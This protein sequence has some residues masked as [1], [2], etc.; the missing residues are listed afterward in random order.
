MAVIVTNGNV[1][2]STA[3]GFYRSIAANF[4]I[5]ATNPLSLTTERLA[6]V[7]F[8]HSEN[9]LGVIISLNVSTNVA[10]VTD[11]VTA[12][13]QEL[14]AA[15]WTTRASSTFNPSTVLCAC[16]QNFSFGAGY[17]V[18]TTAGIWRFRFTATGTWSIG[19]SNGSAVGFVAY[20]DAAVSFV[21]GSDS[22]VIKDNDQLTIDQTASLAN[23]TST[24]GAFGTSMWICKGP[25][26]E[27][28]SATVNDKLLWDASTSRTLT[29]KGA[30]NYGAYCGIR[31]GSESSPVTAAN[32]AVISI[33]NGSSGKGFVSLFT[34]VTNT[35][36]ASLQMWGE[37]PTKRVAQL[38]ADVASGTNT[39]TVD[40]STGFV[41]TDTVFIGGG[42]DSVEYT[43][44]SVP[45]ATSIILTTN[46]AQKHERYNWIHN[47]TEAKH[48]IV[49]KSTSTSAN[50]TGRMSVI[51]HLMIN[52]VRI[53]NI[54]WAAG[55]SSF[56][57]RDPYEEAK[58]FKHCVIIGKSS[59]PTPL[60]SSTHRPGAGGELIE[61]C[62]FNNNTFNGS[63]S[64]LSE[65][66]SS[67]YYQ[68]GV[69]Q[70]KD[71]YFANANTVQGMGRG[72]RNNID[73][74]HWQ[75][76]N[77]NSFGISGL[78]GSIYKN[79]TIH[80]CTIASQIDD[81]PD[82]LIENLTLYDSAIALGMSVN[83]SKL[84]NF[85]CYDMGT[86][87]QPDSAFALMGYNQVTSFVVENGNWVMGMN[88]EGSFLQATLARS[89][90]I[91]F[92]NDNSTT[93]QD[94]VIVA[95]GRLTRTGT[96]L[97]DTTVYGSNL[98]SLR[99]DGRFKDFPMY[100]DKTVL[101][102]NQ[103]GYSMFIYA[104]VKMNSANYWAGST[105]RMPR[106]T[107]T[108]DNGATTTYA[109][110]G[111]S[112]DWQMLSVPITPTTTYPTVDL[113]F[114]SYTDATSTDAYWYIGGYGIVL[115]AGRNVDPG[116]MLYW[117]D[118]FP[119]INTPTSLSAFDV[120][121]VDPATFGTGTVGEIV[122]NTPTEVWAEDSAT[123]TAGT[124][125]EDVL[126]SRKLLANNLTKDALGTVTIYEDDNVTIFKQYKS[127]AE[128]RTKL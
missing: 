31:I 84:I 2:L 86:L 121:A 99:F 19:T 65:I 4:G 102:G 21:S 104:W 82:S 112:T 120:W 69:V 33:T 118:A 38:T 94:F 107:V 88:S 62:L 80:Q 27:S 106:L 24:G 32:Q 122:V 127:T 26:T 6:T 89:S 45:S 81:F 70:F 5:N 103:S 77:T 111:Q 116:T 119:E 115:P 74:W 39:L 35:P 93:N 71:V 92:L 97:T 52:G 49:M 50:A 53:R 20:S 34:T 55:S 67:N 100:L 18:N 64:A 14:V 78:S 124:V 3:G 59:S 126:N 68:S 40:D 10:T 72:I 87:V 91:S 56:W 48:G 128:E 41:A 109:Q 101:I 57:S 95:G 36:G 29:V 114:S 9:L 1:G 16:I 37:Y 25:G 51:T 17:P 7:T 30:I 113:E 73:G 108:Y 8:S 23:T 125:G 43:I 54:A 110:A 98:Y 83:G 42:N 123:F 117:N 75:R 85:N 13:L 90:S 28:P 58:T 11:T 46:V 63:V 15:V 105:Y 66:V 44:S 96:G 47:S 12:E 61:D 22:I 60:Y 79:I 76:T